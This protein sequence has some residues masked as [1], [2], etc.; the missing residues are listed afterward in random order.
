VLE[1]QAALGHIDLIA[2]G[3]IDSK[4]RGL[5]YRPGL[6]DYVTDR[7]GVGPFTQAQLWNKIA[8]GDTLTVMG[9]PPG[10]GLRMGIDR[11]LDGRFDGD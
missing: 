5:R 1:G 8:A 10:S 11:D 2:K 6:D 7:T 3:T 4:I 9:V